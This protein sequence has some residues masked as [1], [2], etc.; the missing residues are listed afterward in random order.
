M[1][2]ELRE[3]ILEIEQIEKNRSIDRSEDDENW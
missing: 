2:T 1:E 3:G